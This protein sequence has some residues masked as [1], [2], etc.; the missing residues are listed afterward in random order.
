MVWLFVEL[1][2]IIHVDIAYPFPDGIIDNLES[3]SCLSVEFVHFAAD[4]NVRRRLDGLVCE[5]HM[6]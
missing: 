5:P 1:I 2:C 4:L 6:D 3:A